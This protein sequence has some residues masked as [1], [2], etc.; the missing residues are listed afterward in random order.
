MSATFMFIDTA[1]VM[2]WLLHLIAAR[3]SSMDACPPMFYDTEATKG[4]L[5]SAGNRYNMGEAR[6][7]ELIAACM[8]LGVRLLPAS[9]TH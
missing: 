5:A 6:K 9:C 8:T 2:I 7:K 1:V 4:A 3:P